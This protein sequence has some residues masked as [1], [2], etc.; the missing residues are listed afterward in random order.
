MNSV[1]TGITRLCTWG[2]LIRSLP[3]GALAALHNSNSAA[4]TSARM[5]RQ[6]SRY[7]APSAVRVMLRVLR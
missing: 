3:F 2:T 7:N 6:R 5:R 4:S 1:S